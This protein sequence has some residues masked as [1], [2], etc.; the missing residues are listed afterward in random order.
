MTSPQLAGIHHVKI[1]VTE[2][3]RS[4]EWYGKVFGFRVAYEFPE[5]DGVVRG[6]AGVMPG[7]GETMVAFRVNPKRPPAARVSTRSASPSPT[8]PISSRTRRTS[9]R[10]MSR[11]PR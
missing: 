2:L 11:T 10:W 6:V 1:P 3:S 9:T 8:A 4:L 5:A 7:L